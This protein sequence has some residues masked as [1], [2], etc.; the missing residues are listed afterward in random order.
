MIFTWTCTVYMY[1]IVQFS[2]LVYLQT[3]RRRT[4][5]TWCCW[6]WVS[7]VRRNTS[8]S[9]SV[10]IKIRAR[11]WPLRAGSTRRACLAC[12]RQE[13]SY[14]CNEVNHVYPTRTL[15]C[16]FSCSRLSARPVAGGARHQRRA[17]GC[18]WGRPWPDGSHV[19][20]RPGRNRPLRPD[21]RVLWLT[22]LHWHRMSFNDE[23]ASIKLFALLSWWNQPSP[24]LNVAHVP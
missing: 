1:S 4:R 9:S 19:T 2:K 14:H 18:A 15:Q 3:L 10:W 24:Q 7:W 13:V 5:P 22:S 21:A 23:V 17:P 11:T 16:N 6:R 12:T 8:S 20:G